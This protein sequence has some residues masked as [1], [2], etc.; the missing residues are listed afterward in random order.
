MLGQ[1]RRRLLALVLLD[2]GDDA[3]RHA[4]APAVDVRRPEVGGAVGHGEVEGKDS[5]ELRRALELQQRLAL[6]G[7]REAVHHPA[8]EG[9]QD[10]VVEEVDGEGHAAEPEEEAVREDGPGRGREVQADGDDV[11]AEAGREAREVGIAGEDRGE[12]VAEVQR[13]GLPVVV[14]VGQRRDVEADDEEE[15]GHGGADGARG[16]GLQ[17]GEGAGVEVLQIGQEDAE[18]ELHAEEGVVAGPAEERQ[19]EGDGHA[20]RL[21]HAGGREEEDVDPEGALEDGHH[22]PELGA[23]LTAAVRPDAQDVVEHG[24]DGGEERVAPVGARLRQTDAVA[25][26]R[27]VEGAELGGDAAERDDE[28]NGEDESGHAADGRLGHGGVGGIVVALEEALDGLEGA[29]VA[30]DHAEDG[31]ANA[32]L[33]EDAE[34]GKLE[35][36]GRLVGGRRWPEQVG[37]PCAGDVL[38]DDEGGGDTTEALIERSVLALRGC[39]RR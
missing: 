19:A 39:R 1:K 36:D 7:D 21:L 27:D 3:L 28:G 22:G 14:G 34:E 31:H 33:D 29:D 6:G 32:A 26:V 16:E 20:P 9:A 10:L 30:R 24:V 38:D 8:E 18:E 17:L 12:E 23:V 35:K 2:D 4:R 5:E 25:V 11:E 37:E 13:P 15:E